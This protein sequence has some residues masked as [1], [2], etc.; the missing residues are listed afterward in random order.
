MNIMNPN[1]TNYNSRVK[2]IQDMPINGG[3]FA[4]SDYRLNYEFHTDF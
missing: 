1:Y 4:F 3:Y 2:N